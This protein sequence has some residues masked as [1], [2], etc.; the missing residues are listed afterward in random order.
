MGKGLVSIDVTVKYGVGYVAHAVKKM[1]SLVSHF[2][3]VE[4]T[5][6][7]NLEEMFSQLLP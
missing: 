6:G 5:V 1:I 4:V 2:N 3:E 7:N